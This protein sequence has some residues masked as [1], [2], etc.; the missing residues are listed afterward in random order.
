MKNKFI[1]LLSLTMLLGLGFASGK[2]QA[3]IAADGLEVDIAN[4]G[5]H[6]KLFDDYYY[7][8]DESFVYTADINFNE[9]QAG[10]L[11][12]GAEDNDHYFVI[13]IDR[14]E[15]RTKLIYFETKPEG[16]YKTDELYTD[17]FIGNNKMTAGENEMVSSRVR[18]KLKSVNLKIILTADEGHTY[19]E[20]F[21][22]GIK[23]FGTDT[24]IDLSNIAGKDFKYEGGYLGLNCFNSNL[25]VDDIEIGSSDYSYMSEQYRNQFH[26]SPFAKWTNDPNALVYYNGYYHCYYQTNPYGQ[27]WDEMYWGHARSTDL[28][29]WEFLP[30]CLFPEK[31][32]Q[33]GPGDAFMWSGCA[34]AYYKG[35]SSLID[36]YNWFPNG[37]GDGLYA[38]FT[39]DGGRQDQVI[40]YSDDD[41]FTWT[42]AIRVPQALI[43]I[44]DRKVDCRDPKVFPMIKTGDKVTLWGMTLSSYALNKGYFLK[45]ENLIDWSYAGEFAL[46]T[47][48]CIGVGAITDE[49]GTVYNYLTNKSRTYML[50]HL[51]YNASSGKI[52]FKDLNN[53][54]ISTHS[55]ETMP[56]ETL[57]YGPDTYASQSF[58]I[59]DPA[60]E[61]C[62]KDLVL[63]WFSGDLNASFCTGPGEYANVR[64]GWNGG[65]TMPVEYSVKYIDEKPVIA[66]TPIT[67]NNTKLEKELIVSKTNEE[68]DLE[69]TN[70][71]EN[72]H[73][74]TF[75]LQTS[76][77]TYN[78]SPIVFKVN[79]SENEYME[80][81]WNK[82]DGYYVDRS[83]LDA[84]GIN[85]N[86]DYHK[87]YSSG[88]LGDSDTKT[89]Y[90]L[91][92]NGGLEVFCEDFKISFYFVTIAS[93]F[94]NNASLTMDGK[95]NS[96]T[97]NEVKS[98]WRGEI[99]PGEGILRLSSDVIELDT[100]FLTSKYV[101][102]YYTGSDDLV[103]E[104]ISG[105]EFI[106]Y[107]VDNHTIKITAK[108]AG[109]AFLKVTA[110][111]SEETLKVK[112]YS[113]AFKSDFTFSKEKIKSG[114]WVMSSDRII[115]ENLNG[116]AFLLANE[117]GSDFTYSGKFSIIEGTAASLVFRSDL[118][119]EHFLVMNYDSNENVVK[120]WN[121]NGE[122]ARSQT[123][124]VNKNEVVLSVTAEDRLIEG[125]I[126]G[127]TVLSYT[128]GEGLPL[129][130]YFGLN[131]FSAKAEFTSL[132][133]LRDEYEY[134]GNGLQI[135]LDV[136]QIIKSIYNLT[137]KNTVVDSAFYSVNGNILTIKDE[138]FET[139][140]ETGLYK[141]KI[142]GALSTFTI[143]VD[144][145]T[146]PNSRETTNVTVDQGYDV[147]IYVGDLDVNS[148]A[149]NGTA[150]TNEEYHIDGD[151]L[152]INKDK[153][154]VGAN[155]VVINNTTVVVVT[156]NAIGTPVTPAVDA[157]TTNNLGLILG[158]SIGGGVLLLSG[159]AL[160]II[161]ILKKKKANKQIKETE[162]KEEEQTDAKDNN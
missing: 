43:G 75:E 118:N 46:P 30:I 20:F 99:A 130:G 2:T 141:F 37:N 134:V 14:Y 51:E 159:A 107:T 124:S 9:G 41:G 50:G 90:V 13:N 55:L 31:E 156:V 8:A 147:R 58:Y 33:F 44:D 26:L 17:Y 38:I 48:E 54:D 32:S 88:I 80:F 160:A 39:R 153:F 104:I 69:S 129:T 21:L 64:D 36:S 127:Q 19:V 53:V 5:D 93:P 84:K 91:S 40:M 56:L 96:L 120:L 63:N 123:V 27:Y 28:I 100:S 34:V 128:L 1:G 29:H 133:L 60:S 62:G 10:G 45:S 106:E 18:T 158:L 67:L 135:T 68:V 86:I 137:N 57:D 101:S 131:V 35:M 23:R 119:M 112:V 16:G 98:I 125:S 4:S 65:F 108:A 61:Y 77:E 117:Q 92:D 114:S 143:K 116:N 102:A 105:E 3:P 52:I 138:Y 59:T 145:K 142:I 146:I 85:T 144:V 15:N 87:K 71:L 66:Q 110:G 79:L 11:V 78:D 6:F 132:S 97:V 73:T 74:N 139:L 81:G 150:L 49:D 25:H 47:P 115:G 42:K 161:L 103:W 157:Q 121:E 89:F 76:I 140:K 122:L 155:D 151:Y 82:T 136:P 95:I 12:F 24:V 113:G 152:V 72:V 126:N 148:V 154:N 83:N 162:V 70:V 109:E 94:S 7:E 149:V 22:E 111:N